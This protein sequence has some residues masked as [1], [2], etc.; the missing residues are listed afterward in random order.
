[1]RTPI[2]VKIS[3]KTRNYKVKR[4]TLLIILK[5]I[6]KAYGLKESLDIGI[7]F[8][9]R[10]TIKRLNRTFRQKDNVTNVLSFSNSAMKNPHLADKSGEVIICLSVAEREAKRYDNDFNDY[11]EFLIIHS[12]LHI[13]GYEH[14]SPG[15]RGKMEKLE[16]K[17][18]SKIPRRIFVL[19]EVN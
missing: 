4:R 17:I 13:L 12:F 5:D 14:V 15:E 11:I 16:E 9:G 8:V 19:R 7:A 10:A 3:N 6:A 2:M 18:F 1:M